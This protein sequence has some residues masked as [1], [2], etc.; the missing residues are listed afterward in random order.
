LVTYWHKNA[1]D[2]TGSAWC[3]SEVDEADYT[4]E[5]E[6]Y[7]YRRSLDLAGEGRTNI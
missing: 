3:R 4:D 5:V 1:R 7:L 2:D 6:H